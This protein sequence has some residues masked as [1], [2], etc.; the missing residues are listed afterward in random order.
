VKAPGSRAHRRQAL[1]PWLVADLLVLKREM[2]RS[3]ISCYENVVLNLDRLA[4]SHGKQGAAQREARSVLGR[5]ETMTMDRMIQGGLHEFL[6][7]FLNDNNRIGGVVAEQ[8][9]FA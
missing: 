2:P 6:E 9:L 5:L 4:R 7:G 3:L 1:R 8:Y